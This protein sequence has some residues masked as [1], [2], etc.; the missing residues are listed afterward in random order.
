MENDEPQSVN[1]PQRLKLWAG[2]LNPNRNPGNQR[3]GIWY[4]TKAECIFE[5]TMKTLRFNLFPKPQIIGLKHIFEEMF[6]KTLANPQM[7]ECLNSNLRQKIKLNLHVSVFCSLTISK[8]NQTSRTLEGCWP[9]PP[10]L[11]INS[12]LAVSPEDNKVKTRPLYLPW[13]SSPFPA[14]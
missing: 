5:V 7:A 4:V 6:P 3:S 11:V 12:P 9:S 10:P 2:F 8:H 1:L 13:K 14:I